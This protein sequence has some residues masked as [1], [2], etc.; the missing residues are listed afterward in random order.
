LLAAAAP[1]PAEFRAMLHLVPHLVTQRRARLWLCARDVDDAQLDSITLE[2]NGV[3][4]P[5]PARGWRRF[6]GET[7]SQRWRWAPAMPLHYQF[8]DDPTLAPGRT[9]EATAQFA[10]EE[11]ARARFTTLPEQLGDETRPLR[12][13]LSSCYFT[14]NKRSRLAATLSARLERNGLRPHLRVWAGDQ[15]YLDAPWYEFTIKTH[16]V[17]ELERLHCTA[18]ARTWFAEQGLS[19]VLPNGANVFCT[20]DHELWNNAPDPSSVARDTRKRVTR[21]AWLDLGRQLGQAFQGDTGTAQR[22]SVPPVDFLVLDVRVHRTEHHESLFS[23]AQWAELRDWAA[24]PRGLGVLVVGQPVFHPR[25]RSRGANADYHLADYTADYTELMDLLSRASR[26]TVVLSGDVHF[27]RVAWASF[28]GG[29]GSSADT[30]VTE[31]ISSPLSMVAGGRLLSLLDGWM[32]A[33]QKMSLPATH[34]FNRA[35]MQTD[36][37]LRS[38]AEGAMLVEFYRRGWRAFCSVTHWRLQDLERPQPHFR[39]EY[40]V[41]TIT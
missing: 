13:L 41:G 19:T 15:V 11:Q 35:T 37:R 27:S 9:Y 10:G 20:D 32:P 38:T 40:F 25:T 30:R 2:V 22:F 7:S 21:E 3:D 6:P 12:V 39:Q 29:G 17:S 24:Q 26:S 18:Y 5:V 36:Q 23:T 14:G 34:S 8:I 4:V 16:S 33:P 1:G 28:P 31:F